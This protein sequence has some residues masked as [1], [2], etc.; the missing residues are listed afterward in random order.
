VPISFLT[1]EQERR[2]GRH[3]G[4]QNVDQLARYFHVDDTDR[5]LA[6][7]KRWDQMRLRLPV[8]LGMVRF[9]TDLA[10]TFCSGVLSLASTCSIFKLA[11]A[12]VAGPLRNR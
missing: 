8:Q 4:E 11:G 12:I 10:S 6:G 2:Y 9:P 3:A 5:E 1:G 7:A